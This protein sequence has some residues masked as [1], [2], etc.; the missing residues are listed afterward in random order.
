MI[1]PLE[2]AL[3][4]RGDDGLSFVIGFEHWQLYDDE[5]SNATETQN[6]GILTAHDNAYDGAE[7]TRAASTDSRGYAA[8]AEEGDQ[9]DLLG[10]LGG[11]LRNMYCR[12]R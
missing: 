7:A 6:F 9:G 1:D 4:L 5:V 10:P 12:A 3:D 8:G 2:A 11:Y